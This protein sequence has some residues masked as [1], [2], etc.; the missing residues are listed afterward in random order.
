MGVSAKPNLD[1]NIY[2]RHLKLRQQEKP[3]PLPGAIRA[4]VD[5]VMNSVS[6]NFQSIVAIRY[7]TIHS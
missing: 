5:K 6:Y 2:A 3:Y 7:L 4:Y 1:E